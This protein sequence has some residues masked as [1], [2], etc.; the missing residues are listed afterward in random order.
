MSALNIPSLAKTFPQLVCA[1][2]AAYGDAVA[3]TLQGE[4]TPAESLSFLELDRN[5]SLLAKG[6]IARGVGK[7]ARIGFIY[8]NNPTFAVL[9][10]AISR[11]GAIAVPIS[12][13][14]KSG[15]LVRIL[16]QSDV[17]GLFVQRKLLGH[18]YVERLCDAMP[19]L[20]A[21]NG[22]DLRINRVPYLRWVVSTGDLLPPSI[23]DM[24]FLNSTACTVSDEMLQEIESEVHTTD[25][26]IE[27]YTS[28]SMALPKGVKHNHGPVLHRTHYIGSMIG[29]ARGMQVTVPLPM[30]WVGGLM[31]YLLP[32]WAAGV[33]TICTEGTSS[34]SRWAMGSV[35]AEDDLKALPKTTT[36]WAL[37]MSET[38]GPYSYGDVLRVPDYPLCAPLDHIAD[39]FEVRVVD[40]ECRAV[41]ENETGEIQV[42]GYAVT[43]GLHKIERAKSFT[44]DGFYRTGDMGTVIGTRILFVGR[45]GD[46]IKTASSNVSPA[47]VEMEIMR[48]EGVH[49]AYVVGLPDRA[50]GQL[51]VAAIV[52]RIDVKLDITDIETNLRRKLSTYKVPRA[53][54][55]LTRDEV[56]MLPSNKVSRRQLERLLAERLGHSVGAAARGTTGGGDV[57]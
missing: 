5:S 1:T 41:S 19:E 20:C 37:G 21:G 11:I 22:S 29:I 50:R 10:A 54:V 52:P 27:I 2:A 24:D 43:P 15:E 8:G 13:L 57:V 46:M 14:A 56:P 32:N 9:L 16:R 30:F 4:T 45:D 47:E 26:M 28:G 33:T 31:L 7:G 23:H 48:F 3:I 34:S 35:L 39:D 12:T 17:M 38:I 18:D 51:V 42:R 55:A 44:P 36:I 40:N 6:L 53:Y 25:Q 49:S